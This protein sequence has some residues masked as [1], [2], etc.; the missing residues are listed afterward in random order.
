MSP[1]HPMLFLKAYPIF[2]LCIS[3]KSQW[4]PHLQ[5]QGTW[6]WLWMTNCPLLPTCSCT[7]ILHKKDILLSCHESALVL[8][9]TSTDNFCRSSQT[10]SIS[11]F[12]YTN[13][14][15]WWLLI[16]HLRY[17]YLPV[18]VQR[19]HVH[20]RQSNHTR[21]PLWLTL[22]LTLHYALLLLLNQLDGQST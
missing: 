18:V 15:H 11:E 2:G 14:D 16:F 13:T 5:Q 20:Q 17:F 19:L 22:K 8:E 3:I 4:C 7:F 9:M 12:S 1:Q 21:Q 6:V 10:M